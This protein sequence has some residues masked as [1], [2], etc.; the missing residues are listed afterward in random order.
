MCYMEYEGVLGGFR[1]H[2]WEFQSIFIG[3][4]RGYD[5]VFGSLGGSPICYMGYEGVFRGFQRV[6]QVLQE[7]LGAF[8]GFR[9]VHGVR[10]GFQRLYEGV[11]VAYGGSYGVR[12]NFREI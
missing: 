3:F 1:R 9:C 10:E 5:G 4:D 2:S 12:G 6:L 7:L 11:F 8:G